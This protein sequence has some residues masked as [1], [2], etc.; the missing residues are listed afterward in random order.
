MKFLPT[1][2]TDT[3]SSWIKN[4]PPYC[5]IL[6]NCTMF[7]PFTMA[8]WGSLACSAEFLGGTWGDLGGLR[9]AE[10]QRVGLNGGTLEQGPIFWIM[11]H[12]TIILVQNP[13]STWP[14]RCLFQTDALGWLYPDGFLRTCPTAKVLG[15]QAGG[16]RPSCTLRFLLCDFRP[17]TDSEFKSVL[18]TYPT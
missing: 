11:P 1:P 3:N 8:S 16:S 9:M 13:S 10:M 12:S 18:N 6:G 2:P 5:L 17:R 4:F 14:I 7:K 15:P